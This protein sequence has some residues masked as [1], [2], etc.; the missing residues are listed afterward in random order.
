MIVKSGMATPE[1]FNS[2]F[3]PLRIYGGIEIVE[4]LA[5][6]TRH[7]DWSGCR[8]KARARR[9]MLQGHRQRVRVW[10]EPCS[11]RIELPGRPPQIIVH[12]DLMRD[13]RARLDQNDGR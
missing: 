13:L 1:P 9:R 10:H 6:V 5:A 7:E 4:S 8:S 3:A 11:Y 2:L 12:P